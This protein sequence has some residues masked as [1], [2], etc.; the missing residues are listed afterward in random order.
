MLEAEAEQ[1]KAI[2]AERQAVVE[3]LQEERKR[4]E[5]AERG[6][7]NQESALMAERRK[8]E[9]VPIVHDIFPR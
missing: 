6:F 8:R 5:E 7:G 2:E 3:E 4:R 1:T 9:Q